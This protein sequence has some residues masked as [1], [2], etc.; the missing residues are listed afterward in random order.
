M[1]RQMIT[2]DGNEAA[3]RVAHKL[4][5]V[6]A[7]Y[8]ITPSSPMGEHSDTWSARG[9]KNIWGTVPLV[10]E[11][12]SEGGASAAVHGALQ[13]GALTTTFTAS[14][15]L[16]LMIPTMYK[17]AGE[18]TPTVFHVAARSLAA[19]ALSIFGDHSDVMAV[20]NTGFGLLSSASV[21]EVTDL[22]AIAHA[23]TLKSRIPFVHFFDGFRTSHEIQKIE[24]LDDDVLKKMIDDELV[25]AHRMR[26]LNPNRP[27][28][29]GTSQNPDVYFQG[30][31]SVNPYY[32]A[33]PAIV[34]EYMD[35]FGKLT[36]RHYH[37]FDYIGAPDAE[38]IMILMGSGCEVAH[39]TVEYLAAQGEKVG[40]I[41]VRLYRPFDAS[42]LLSAIPETAKTVS[43][44]DRTKEPGNDG[45][46]LYKD[47]STAIKAAG[48]TSV[49]VVGGRFGLSSKEFTPASVKGVFNNAQGELKNNFTVGI[50]D[51]LTYSSI[52]IPDFALKTKGLIQ[53]VFMGLG[54]DGTVGA[55][56]NS[57]K[58]IGETTN[59][60]AQGYFVYDS[61]KAGALTVSHL[62]FGPEKIRRT[63]L[64][65]HA[66][67]VACHQTVFIEK[68]DILHYAAD[69]ATF[70]LNTSYGPG[71]IWDSLP[72]KVQQ[73]MIKK[74]IEFY[75]ID[76]YKVAQETGMGV[77]INTIMQTCFFAISGVLEK[78]EAIN[79]I[80][81]AIQK[82]YGKK[83][84]DVVEKNFAA[85]DHALAGLHKVDCPC[86][87]TSDTA[88]PPV[89][90]AEAPE[91][92]QNVT[93]AI[94]AQKG[95][96][97]P[98]SA[99][100]ADGTWPTATTQWE[101]RNI[102]L[103]IPVW[104]PEVC[105]QCGLCNLVCSHAAIRMKY[106]D[107]ALLE[108]APETF[109]SADGN[110]K[111]KAYKFTN[112]ISP[113]D[114]T[115]CGACVHVCPARNRTVE[116]R[117]AINMQPQSP[118][119]HDEVEN[120]KFFLEI[121]DFDRTELNLTTVKESQL[122]RPLFEYSGACAGCGET[123][124]VK[125]LSQLY[126]DRAVI[127]NATGCSS[128]YGGN[129]PTTPYAKDLSGRGPAWNNSLFEDAAEFGYGFRLTTDKHTETA[130]ELITEMADSLD[131]NLVDSLLNSSIKTELEIAQQRE[132][133]EYLKK[134]LARIDT[135]Q[136]RQ[137][138]TLAD[139]FV[140]RSVWI[141]G[142]DGWAYDIGY[143]GLDHVLAQGRNVNVLVLDTGVYSN[144]GGQCSKATPMGA[145]AKFAAAGKPMPKKDLAMI[146]M[147]YGNIYVAQVAMGAN[148]NQ[149][150][151]AFNE[152][153]SFDG[154]S[155]IIAYSHCIAHG[156]DMTRGMDEHKLVVN[157]GMWPLFRFDP[158][159]IAL[160]ESPLQL[161]S[162]KPSIPFHKLAEAEG[163]W[164]S[165]MRSNP[166]HAEELLAEAQKDVEKRFHLYEQMAKMDWSG[167]N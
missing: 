167:E 114:C 34:Q 21:Q 36:G 52:E 93:A 118:L 60:Y 137:L 72:E 149:T 100:P 105:I 159:K 110:T 50:I 12:Q 17:I 163:R 41:K 33:T 111:F 136:A 161:D 63:C 108:N 76:A 135:P 18:L 142:G 146:S 62:R 40:V 131:E 126:G 13:T 122:L 30:R 67:F 20:R 46:P 53:A 125:L 109:K 3:A 54:S 87:A 69:G 28:V 120:Y 11:M 80:K 144:T 119:R 153:E 59:N 132:R 148:W 150:V 84:K 134:A 106:Y 77:M 2:I 48:R 66:S 56:K 164:S 82:T 10:Q 70:L 143:G 74:N 88:V 8:P 141:I 128:I 25:Y 151:K 31:E 15:G 55:N 158:R 73:E 83:G 68:Y 29:R 97:I 156:I 133:V 16:L 6:V 116:G 64:I 75:V 152:A 95:N 121:P 37:L 86:E 123:P 27:V 113:E 138:E 99:M 79:R 19:Q 78:N 147:T 57:I 35:L 139:Y 124:Y 85:V 115:G 42:A 24:A 38:H 1:S 51:D 23:A 7:I 162:R 96:D 130:A 43:V 102:A 98:V 127:A 112:Q 65:E 140:P 58:I 14:Q 5:E 107:E 71:E 92:V 45:E 89:V 104:D 160:G 145:V 154:P 117:K 166:A 81:A 91:F 26:G 47:V 39:E 103:E 90:S 44:L 157:S 165:L 61:K 94:M 9:Q 129:L 32:E 155:L 22:A 49:K 101:K 4:S